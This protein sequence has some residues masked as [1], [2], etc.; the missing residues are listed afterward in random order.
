[1]F[2]RGFPP[3]TLEAIGR[4]F[5]NSNSATY[6]IS[7]AAEDVM[8][9]Y[10]SVQS[11]PDFDFCASMRGST[12]RIRMYLYKRK[13]SC[14]SIKVNQATWINE[15]LCSPFYADPLLAEACLHAKSTI[16]KDEISYRVRCYHEGRLPELNTEVNEVYVPPNLTTLMTTV[17]SDNSL[18]YNKTAPIQELFTN[19]L[20]TLAETAGKSVQI[21]R[22]FELQI[23][24]YILILINEVRI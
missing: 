17:Q 21:S 18:L 2:D 16:M 24:E 9:L 4:A 14:S 20:P 7:C 23:T 8:T 13:A 19:G 6:I 1:M 11:V 10:F 15:C 5:N 3:P 12:Q 22:I